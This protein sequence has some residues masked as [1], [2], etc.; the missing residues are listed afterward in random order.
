MAATVATSTVT[1]ALSRDKYRG[2]VVEVRTLLLRVRVG[3]N[4][5]TAL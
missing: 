2:A 4:T 3:G 5:C 1:S